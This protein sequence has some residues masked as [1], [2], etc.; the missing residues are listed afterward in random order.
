LKRYPQR[1]IVNFCL[2][3]LLFSLSV[4]PALAGEDAARVSILPLTTNSKNEMMSLKQRIMAMMTL[5]ISQWA[6]RIA[7]NPRYSKTMDST[8]NNI[9]RSGR[10]TR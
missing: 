6:G 8:P 10:K 9:L 5:R 1:L 3:T 7:A 2:L 4:S